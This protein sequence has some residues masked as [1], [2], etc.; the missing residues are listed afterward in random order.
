MTKSEIT[1]D[2]TCMR[3]Q[4]LNS[5]FASLSALPGIGP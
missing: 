1:S 3:P 4:V 5:L 2:E